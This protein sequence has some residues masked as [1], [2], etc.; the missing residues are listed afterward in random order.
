MQ[1]NNRRKPNKIISQQNK[2]REREL[3]LKLNQTYYF[4]SNKREIATLILT[5]MPINRERAFLILCN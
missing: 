5:A 1:I 2:K 4:L 3:I